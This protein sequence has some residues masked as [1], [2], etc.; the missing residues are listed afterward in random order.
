ML[1][2]LLVLL[3]AKNRHFNFSSREPMTMKEKLHLK[4]NSSGKIKQKAK[5]LMMIKAGYQIDK[6]VDNGYEQSLGKI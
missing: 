3:R 1:R 5:N 4:A 6:A 2:E